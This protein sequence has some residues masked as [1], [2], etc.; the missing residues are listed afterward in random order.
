MTSQRDVDKSLEGAVEHFFRPMIT[1]KDLPKQGSRW[2]RFKFGFRI[3][4]TALSLAN[5]NLAL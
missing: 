2:S 1:R 5:L 3:D 4:N